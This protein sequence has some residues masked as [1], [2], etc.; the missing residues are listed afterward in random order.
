MHEAL[1]ASPY[2]TTNPNE[3]DYFYVPVYGT[4][5]AL[6][7]L[8]PS[9]TQRYTFDAFNTKYSSRNANRAVISTEVVLEAYEYI[10]TTLPYWNASYGRDHLFLFVFDEGSSLAP[11][12]IR[13]ATL[14]SHF[15]NTGTP[16]NQGTSTY[17]KWWFPELV[18]GL[19]GNV[20][21]FDPAKDIVMPP[22]TFLKESFVYNPNARNRTG[23]FFFGGRLGDFFPQI[24]NS[25]PVTSLA[26]SLGIRQRVARA[27][28]NT[29]GFSIRG[30]LSSE[31]YIANMQ[32]HIFCGSFPGDG[33]SG[34]LQT[35]MK[36]GCIP[37]IIQDGILPPFHDVK[38][39]VRVYERDI[40]NLETILRSKTKDEIARLQDQ[41]HAHWKKMQYKADWFRGK[42][43]WWEDG[44]E[45]AMHH[46]MN[47]LNEKRQC[48]DGI[49]HG[50]VC[51]A[52][53]CG[54]TC[55]GHNCG[56][57]GG[58]IQGCCVQTIMQSN[59]YCDTNPPPCIRV[60]V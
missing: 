30:H 26:Y 58:G 60:I 1:L 51:C 43:K 50:N 37:V 53:S 40:E 9:P 24:P 38:Y 32:S 52:G 6:N 56:L 41:V 14:L 5:K 10:S 46:L 21:T 31:D 35:A 2:R 29:S 59:K 48:R 19:Y 27:F 57:R 54:S 34:A 12:K 39:G 3:A 33:W 17:D 55:G 15:G 28:W 4:C 36:Y 13:N 20:T 22:P 49:L 7:T 47:V 42:Q 44:D 25:G 45:Y 8:A 23:L 18:N 11:Q 16:H